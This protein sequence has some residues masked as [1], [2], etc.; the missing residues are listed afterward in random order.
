MNK[1]SSSELI[2][3]DLSTVGRGPLINDDIAP[4]RISQR[5]WTTYNIAALWISMSACIPTY[6]LASSL[7]SEGMN[8]YQAVLTVFLGNAIVLVPMIVIGIA[9]CM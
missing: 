4:T 7:I 8:W 9:C 1:P 6:M 2:E 5:T 3:V